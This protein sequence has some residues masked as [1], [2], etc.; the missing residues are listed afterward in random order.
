M[1]QPNLFLNTVII[2]FLCTPRLIN[3]V[4]PRIHS[5]SF[6]SVAI[7]RVNEDHLRD[8]D[9]NASASAQSVIS[10]PSASNRISSSWN[11]AVLV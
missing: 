11:C 9:P 3:F 8:G 1:I 5:L 4:E 10:L 2:F 6:H 7:I